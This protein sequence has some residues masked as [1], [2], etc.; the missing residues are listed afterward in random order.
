M[1]KNS[2]RK[3]VV[4]GSGIGGLSIGILLGDLGYD[5]TILEKNPLP[6]GLLRSY[7]RKG[8]EC[9]VGVHYLG[10]LGEGEAL[11]RLFDYFGV[12]S[13]I[14]V[15]KMGKQGV[16][17][18]YVF[19]DEVTPGRVFD[20]PEGLDAYR[21]NLESAFPSERKQIAAFMELLTDSAI[22]LQ[23][24]SFLEADEIDLSLLEQMEPLGK[25]LDGI[26]CSPELKC[27]IGVPACW[28]G[29][30]PSVCPTY[31]HNMTLASYL[32]SSWRLKRSGRKMAESFCRRFEGGGGKIVSGAEAS[33]VLVESKKVL[34]IVLNTGEKID[35]DYVVAAIHPQKL[36]AMLSEGSVKPSYRRRVERLENTEGFFS[37][38][39]TLDSA[40]HPEIPHN[41]FKIRPGGDGAV[42]D[43]KY[44]QIRATKNSEKTLLT[45]MSSG[46]TQAWKPWEHTTTG[47]RGS[48]YEDM[49]MQH[50]SR[51]IEEAEKLLGPFHGLELLDASTPLTIRDY[52]NSPNGSAYGVR[53]SA[54]Q[55]LDASLLNRTSVKGLYLAG[56]S[57]SAP[58]IL[59]TIIG[60]L[61]TLKLLTGPEKFRETNFPFFSKPFDDIG[62][63]N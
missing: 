18:R 53:R 61:L 1:V 33:K 36:L 16:I 37:V 20:M 57:V 10:S 47:C 31:Y 27:V 17:D 14:P 29:V 46:K 42:S 48:F 44:Y 54:D 59:G 49:K 4:V 30:P 24:L 8:I 21:A 11:A 6:G 34:G 22:R 7:A 38:H 5:V 40:F 58:G 45:I 26:G 2:E 39:A 52:V 51:L 55:L 35:A 25:V 50:A 15:E 13:E 3:V 32:A 9:P 12:T 60:S 56:Q 19:D 43:L 63:R 41:I 23:S 62:L 28:I